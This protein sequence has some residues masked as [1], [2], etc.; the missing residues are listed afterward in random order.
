MNEAFVGMAYSSDA[1]HL[2]N[3]FQLAKTFSYS[4]LKL[5]N[6]NAI[7]ENI[8]V[9]C[10]SMAMRR[11]VDWKMTKLIPRSSSE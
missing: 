4:K 8:S 1:L 3:T 5:P 6:V 9:I 11:E 2:Q 7:R 10:K